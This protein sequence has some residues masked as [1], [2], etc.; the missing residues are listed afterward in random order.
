MEMPGWRWMLLVLLLGGQRLKTSGIAVLDSCLRGENAR[1]HRITT[2]EA[3]SK[4]APKIAEEFESAVKDRGST[5]VCIVPAGPRMRGL[6]PFG[7]ASIA[8][9]LPSTIKWPSGAFV[10][11]RLACGPNPALFKPKGSMIRCKY[12]YK[13]QSAAGQ[14]QKKN[15]RIAKISCVCCTPFL[16][17]SGELKFVAI[18]R[19]LTP[20]TS[21]ISMG[22]GRVYA[23]HSRIRSRI[24]LDAFY[25]KSPI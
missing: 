21:F 13:E 8:F 20:S 2:K 14:Y 5:D 22:E 12:R 11:P 4:K 15:P 7:P 16:Y 10:F 6:S 3:N 9:G 18:S 25:S 24:V 23:E 19:T 1:E 17:A